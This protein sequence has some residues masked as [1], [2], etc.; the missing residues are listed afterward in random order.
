MPAGDATRVWFPEMLD[1]L[2]LKWNKD[3]PWEA[4]FQICIEETAYR[5]SIKQ[6]KG[7]KEPKIKCKCCTEGEHYMTLAPISVRSLLFALRKIDLIDDE[8]LK[9]KDKE[10]KSYQRKNKLDAYGNPKENKE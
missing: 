7:I 8:Y 1:E 10:W 3:L 9:A 2:K 6:A 4:W 5:Q